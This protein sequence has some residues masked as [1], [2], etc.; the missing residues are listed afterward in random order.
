ME[1]VTKEDALEWAALERED[2][3]HAAVTVEQRYCRPWMR[4]DEL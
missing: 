1:F 2:Y 3:H 4:V